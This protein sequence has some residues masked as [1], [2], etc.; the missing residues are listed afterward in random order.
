MKLSTWTV[1]GQTYAR[2]DDADEEEEDGR[3]LDVVS[4]TIDALV[5]VTPRRHRDRC[6]VV[7]VLRRDVIRRRISAAVC[8][9]SMYH[10]S[11]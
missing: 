10:M 8:L 7:R 11:L 2:R 9:T 5:P 3:V 6:R 4:A 1:T